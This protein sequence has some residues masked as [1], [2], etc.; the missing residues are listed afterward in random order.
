MD[1]STIRLNEADHKAL[2]LWAHGC[3]IRVLP[4]FTAERPEDTRL[5]EALQSLQGWIDGSVEA[6]DVHAASFGAHSAAR[7]ADSEEARQAA[8]TAAHAADT[9]RDPIHA[10]IAANYARKAVSAGTLGEGPEWL[11]DE[12]AEQK[13]TAP[14]H[15]TAWTKR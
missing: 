9:A 12:I 10:A 1:E 15:L 2:A 7:E 5:T 3:A 6:T 4:Y 13:R 14:E 11:E 8:R